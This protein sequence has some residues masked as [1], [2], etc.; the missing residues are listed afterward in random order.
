[1]KLFVLLASAV[2]LAMTSIAQDDTTSGKV[3]TIKIGGMIIIKKDGKDG[4]NRNITF[5]NRR[6]NKSGNVSTN[7]WIVDLGFANYTDKTNYTAA[8][9]SGFVSPAFG[10][11]DNLKLRTGKS[12][13][14][15]IW[16][17]M[18]KLNVIKHVV[19]LK[20]GLGVELNNYR[21]DDER[22]RFSKNPTTI[23]IDP[24]LAN[25]DKNKLAADYVTV[26]VMLNFNFTPGGKRGF[27]LSAGISAGYLYSARQKIKD[28]GDKTKLHDD[29]NLDKWKLSYI[30]ELNLGPVRLYGSM[31]TKSM[32]EKSLD[33]TPYNIGIRFSNF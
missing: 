30:A 24:A 19:N 1:M 14:V 6:R 25:V 23:S 2:C 28:D 20:Y 11:K 29:F 31:A 16:A 9:Q 21:F 7:W 22:V 33:Q 10:S 12:V 4:K 15:N 17:F 32:W 26:P 3:D 27:G 5:S 8:Q 18:Q 13:N